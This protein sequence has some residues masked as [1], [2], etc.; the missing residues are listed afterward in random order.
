MNVFVRIIFLILAVLLN[1]NISAQDKLTIA[2]VKY[3]G[4]GDWYN[5]PSAIPN[6]LEFINKETGIPVESEE[7]RIDLTDEKLFSY[8]ILFLTGHGKIRFNEIEAR[9]LREFLTN[10]GFLYA[11][12]DY[13]MDK[14]FRAELKKV[15]AEYDLIELPFSHSIYHIHF[16]FPNGPPKIH[17]HDGGPPHGYGIFHNGRMVV[18]YT[19]D[20]NISDGWPD[21]EIH[22]DTPEIREAAFKMGTNIILWILM[23]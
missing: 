21:A 15:F 12:D 23:N 3:G 8:P 20:T 19:A 1:S 2:R 18:Y 7:S 14:Y 4:G 9:R 13:G 10:G 22:K 17:E 6:L 16:D 5:D 11:D